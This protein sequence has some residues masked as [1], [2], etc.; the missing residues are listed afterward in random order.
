MK[1]CFK[2]LHYGYPDLRKKKGCGDN[3]FQCC[4]RCRS[5]VFWS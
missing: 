5:F 3:L 2:C 1:M 4:S